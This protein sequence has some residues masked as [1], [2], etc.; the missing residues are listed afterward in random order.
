MGVKKH[1]IAKQRAAWSEKTNW[2]KEQMSALETSPDKAYCRLPL[3]DLKISD[4]PTHPKSEAL[5]IY[6]N[7]LR[8]RAPLPRRTSVDPIEI[9]ELLPNAGL[10]DVE[11]SDDLRFKIRL[12]GTKASDLV[13]EERTGLYIDDFGRDLSH[14]ERDLAIHRWQTVC[15]EAC[16]TKQPVFTFGTRSDPKRLHHIVHT[17]ALPLTDDGESVSQILGLMVLENNVEVVEKQL[18]V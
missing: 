16:E 18:P 17:A 12:F 1:L 2:I 10:I 8:E 7:N 9:A 4:R 13:G 11:Q 5:W 6:W 3:L 14:A 15:R